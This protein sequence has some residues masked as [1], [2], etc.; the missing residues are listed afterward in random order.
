[1]PFFQSMLRR[2]S[3]PDDPDVL[4]YRERPNAV[5]EVRLPLELG[6]LWTYVAVKLLAGAVSSITCRAPSSAHGR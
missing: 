1:M 6:L 2:E 3:L 4:V 5:C